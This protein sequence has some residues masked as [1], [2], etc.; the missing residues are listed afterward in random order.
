M[1][2]TVRVAFKGVWV[3]NVRCAIANKDERMNTRNVELRQDSGMEIAAITWKHIQF[4]SILRSEPWPTQGNDVKLGRHPIA[5]FH[6]PN[7]RNG[8]WR[9]CQVRALIQSADKLVIDSFPS[10][11]RAKCF[12]GMLGQKENIK[13]K[14]CA[15]VM[16]ESG[17]DICTLSQLCCTGPPRLVESSSIRSDREK[18]RDFGCT[19]AGSFECQQSQRISNPISYSPR[20]WKNHTWRNWE[21]G[22]SWNERESTTYYGREGYPDRHGTIRPSH[23]CWCANQMVNQWKYDSLSWGI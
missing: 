23:W 3:L 16:F 14:V 6:T 1:I 10:Y 20:I 11:K 4:F 19:P 8:I 9:K 13:T 18:S 22:P 15:K 7:M 17:T 2:I 12:A 5:L 21:R